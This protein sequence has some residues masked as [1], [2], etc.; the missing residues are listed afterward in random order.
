MIPGMNPKILV[1]LLCAAAL[2]YFLGS[3]DP[4]KRSLVYLVPADFT[5]PVFVFFDQKDGAATETD[6]LGDAVRVPPN[7]IL[8]L[9]GSVDELI[10]DPDQIS[11]NVKWIS[12]NTA[13]ERSNI[14]FHHNTYE[15]S[16]GQRVNAYQGKDGQ[17]Y[18]HPVPSSGDP[19]YYLSQEQKIQQMI[20]A[21][22]SCKHQYFV[23]DNSGKKPPDCAKFMVASPS[24]FSKIP[25]SVWDELG[26]TYSSIAELESSAVIQIAKMRTL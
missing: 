10:G 22:D 25:N 21:H 9:K 12:V 7:G 4:V 16:S 17:L 15:N 26:G 20:F 19:F 8:R 13:G 24:V 18:E 3:Q 11:G 14:P 2:H 6:P 23:P 5:G 1:F